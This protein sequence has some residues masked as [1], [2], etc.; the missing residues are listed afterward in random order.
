MKARLLSEPLCVCCHETVIFNVLSFCLLHTELS[1]GIIQGELCNIQCQAWCNKCF[2]LEW[3]K[4]VSSRGD[5]PLHMDSIHTH[6]SHGYSSL[7]GRSQSPPPSLC[8]NSD[9]ARVKGRRGT[10]SDRVTTELES[11]YSSC[12]GHYPLPAVSVLHLGF[13]RPLSWWSLGSDREA[14]CGPVLGVAESWTRL[15]N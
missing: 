11:V 10:K 7:I 4:P 8:S 3:T 1:G 13:S 12:L 15:S 6:V 9:P 14:W 2:L 5:S